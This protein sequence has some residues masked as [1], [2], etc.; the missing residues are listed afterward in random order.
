MR[1]PLIHAHGGEIARVQ[2]LHDDHNRPVVFIVQAGRERPEKKV[3]RAL[4][5]D[6]TLGLQG[7]VR[8]IHDDEI[9]ALA[10]GGPPMDVAVMMPR[11]S[12]RYSV[13]SL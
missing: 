9:P 8:V 4:P 12:F 3:D 10:R 11:R 13:F 5:L 6:V 7:I 1:I 2:S